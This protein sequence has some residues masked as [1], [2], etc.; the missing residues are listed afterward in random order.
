MTQG[1]FTWYELMTTDTEAAKAFYGDVM[2]WGN[3]TP[4]ASIIPYTLFTVNDVPSSG[5]MDL[6]KE[7]RTMGVPPNWVGS[8][9]VDDVDGAAS[10]AASL[11]A[12]I[13]CQPMDIP[14]V[15][16]FATIADPTGAVVVLL[17]W[18]MAGGTPEADM[19]SIGRVGWHELIT[20]DW[21]RAFGF[22]QAMFGW[23]KAEA[24]DIGEMGTYQLFR[25][26][27]RMIGGMMNRPPQMPVS[28]WLFYVNVPA[29]DAAVERAM[30][31]GGKLLNGPVQVPGGSWV[32]QC[33]DPQGAVFAMVAPGR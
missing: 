9:Y 27:D 8:I 17:Q 18:R 15:G 6:P 7:L 29:I 14:D 16:R 30:A 5:L 28:A 10:K 25:L 21:P 12:E 24:M 13:K 32:A 20:S 11:G 23:E 4:E 33:M 3:R 26:G 22:Y 1:E 31:G 2:G 19:M